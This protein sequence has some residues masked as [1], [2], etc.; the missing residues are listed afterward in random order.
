MSV[1]SSCESLTD[2]II[3]NSVTSIEEDAFSN[4]KSLTSI[5]IPNSVTSIENF[6]FLGCSSLTDVTIPDSVTS[7][8]TWAFKDCSSLTSI[9]IPNSVTSIGEAVF[10]NCNDLTDIYYL[11][12]KMKWKKISISEDAI[13]PDVTIH[14][15]EPAT[16]V[17][18][19]V[20]LDGKVDILDAVFL[21]KYLA[22]MVQFSDVQAANADC[23]QDDVLNEK[24]ANALLQ[25]VILLIDDLPVPPVQE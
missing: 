21:N 15:V 4:C 16:T 8:G 19:D 2:I 12:T 10:D 7:I 1:F 23:C 13:S 17:Y 25:F 11:D 3:P 5:T 20:N 6:V 22:T 9:T 14:F 18:G 24:D